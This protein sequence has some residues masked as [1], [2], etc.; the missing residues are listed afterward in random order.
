MNVGIAYLG[1]P[2]D[3][4]PL[5]LEAERAGAAVFTCGETEHSAFGCCVAA[6]LG[7]RQ[8]V[9]GTSI[10]IAFARSPM[11][12]AMEAY[13]M[14]TLGPGRS[15]YGLGSQIKQV[16][17]RRFSAEFDPPIGRL[18]EYAEIMRRAVKAKQGHDVEPFE[19][20]FYNVSQFSF[21]GPA[22][23]ELGEADLRL[24]AVGPNMMALAAESF[25][26]M[27]GH[28]VATPR[29]IKEVVRPIIGDLHL[30]SA[31]MT[32]VDDDVDAARE[33]A[34]WALA[35][36]GTTPAY[37]PAFAVEGHPDLPAALRRT[38]RAEGRE[39]AMRLIPEDVLN[40]FMVIGRPG[41]VAE[42]LDEYDGLVDTVVLG[43]IGVG[44]TQK[45]IVENNRHLVKVVEARTG[46]VGA[47]S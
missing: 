5:A 33:R 11:A 1:S 22:E 42:R 29:Y 24:A 34:R 35:F 36:Y 47:T 17:E 18:R 4:G 38:L 28:G 6:L 44:A 45:E 27:L 30:T 2:A 3:A 31:V 9:V 7:T 25:D 39:A 41:E 37:Q 19:G 46:L 8:I 13:S 23:P 15:F 26:G 20:R 12:A 21:F 14:L 40:R 10:A 16:V 43:G 32:S